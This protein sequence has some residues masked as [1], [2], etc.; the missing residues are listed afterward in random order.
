MAVVLECKRLKMERQLFGQHAFFQEIPSKEDGEDAKEAY[1]ELIRNHGAVQKSLGR[2]ILKG[3]VRADAA[4]PIELMDDETGPRKSPGEYDIRS[5]LMKMHV[6]GTRVFQ[7]IF[8]DFNGQYVG[9]FTA[10]TPACKIIA[11]QVIAAPSGYIKLKLK[12]RGF[13]RRCIKDLIKKSFTPEAAN[14]ASLAKMC[15][16]TGRIISGAEIRRGE[17]NGALDTG[18]I[19]DRMAGLTTAERRAME[20]ADAVIKGPAIILPDMKPGAMGAFEFGEED[21]INTIHPQTTGARS[22]CNTF[23]VDEHSMYTMETGDEDVIEPEDMDVKMRAVDPQ[24]KIDFGGFINL[25]DD[26]EEKGYASEYSSA[27]SGISPCTLDKRL[28]GISVFD[29]EDD[30]WGDDD[31]ASRSSRG[32]RVEDEA[33]MDETM[34]DLRNYVDEAITKLEGGEVTQCE[35][36]CET[37]E[38]EDAAPEDQTLP[39]DGNA[40]NRPIDGQLDRTSTATSTSLGSPNES[41]G[42]TE[43]T[44]QASGEANEAGKTGDD[45]SSQA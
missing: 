40:D 24:V 41:L 26:K 31:L 16:R 45:S 8:K 27:A 33:E 25:G 4:V 6:G 1:A 12:K 2:A 39:G 15:R 32:T 34:T 13:S 43:K 19:I 18:G 7:A 5:I 21:T 30:S 28:K 35:N 23:L 10:L 17:H 14:D 42:D 44:L 22:T 29:M 20:M 36:A 3:L 37:L 9:F 11:E 38:G